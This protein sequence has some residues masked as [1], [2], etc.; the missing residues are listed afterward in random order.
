MGWLEIYPPKVIQEAGGTG[1]AGA[2]KKRSA[3]NR[4]QREA[5]RRNAPEW[6]ARDMR[7]YFRT[8]W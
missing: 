7:K 4:G 6:L 8:S 5:G 3:R 1:D 2:A